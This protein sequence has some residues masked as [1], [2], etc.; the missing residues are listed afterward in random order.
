MRIKHTTLMA[1]PAGCFPPGTERDV[2]DADGRALVAGNYAT[3][4]KRR[5]PE[6]AVGRP[7]ETAAEQTAAASLAN[8]A[9]TGRG[10]GSSHKKAA[11]PPAPTFGTP[12]A[13]VST[14]P[15]AE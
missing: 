3:E 1:G 15:A 6:A 11:V 13:D 12:S 8:I 10:R 2:P 5:L 9:G 4:I 7:R 14:T